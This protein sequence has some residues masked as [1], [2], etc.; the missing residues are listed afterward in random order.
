MTAAVARGPSATLPM[1][2]AGAVLIAAGAWS[3]LYL[4]SWMLAALLGA[5]G[6]A[7]WRLAMTTRPFSPWLIALDAPPSRSSPIMRNDALGFWQL[8]G[9]WADVPHFNSAGARDRATSIYAVGSIA[10]AAQP[11]SRPAPDRGVGLIAIP[12]LFN[13]LV[14]SAPTGTWRSSARS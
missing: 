11:L 1:I 8:P 14:R 2:L 5:G 6:L 10:G 9:P 13:L 7:L 12:F 3:S 4:Q